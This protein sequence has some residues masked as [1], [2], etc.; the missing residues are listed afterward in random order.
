QLLEL[1]ISHAANIAIRVVVRLPGLGRYVSTAF[2][3]HIV[4]FGNK[5]GRLVRVLSGEPREQGLHKI[6]AY[7]LLAAISLG[8]FCIADDGPTEVI[9]PKIDEGL[10]V[11]CR[12][13][14]KHSLQSSL[15]VGCGHRGSPLPGINRVVETSWCALSGI[16]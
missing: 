7:R 15:V 12:K 16:A 6:V 8:P 3:Y 1:A 2:N 5:P 9:C 11:A 14:C 4:V 10:A 13:F